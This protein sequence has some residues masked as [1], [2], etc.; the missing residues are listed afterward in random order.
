V[1]FW[2]MSRRA[3]AFEVIRAVVDAAARGQHQPPLRRF[4]TGGAGVGK[5]FFLDS[6]AVILCALKK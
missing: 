6:D 3:D 5:S 1:L 2:E 4:V